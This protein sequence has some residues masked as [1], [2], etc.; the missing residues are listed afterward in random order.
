MLEGRTGFD[1]VLSLR[2]AP[3]RVKLEGRGGRGAPSL[4]WCPIP[5]YWEQGS[6]GYHS[7]GAEDGVKRLSVISPQQPLFL[8]EA[9]ELV[10]PVL[11]VRNPEVERI[12]IAADDI[13]DGVLEKGL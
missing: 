2:S 4:R 8:Q 3:L 7:G 13:N 9:M 10:I 6:P 12:S 11:L 5:L 1:P